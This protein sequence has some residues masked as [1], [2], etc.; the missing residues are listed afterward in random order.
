MG[1]RDLYDSGA[2]EIHDG[3]GEEFQLTVHGR[4]GA[5]WE[6]CASATL[7]IGTGTMFSF[8]T[9]GEEDL[10]RLAGEFAHAANVIRRHEDGVQ[11][12]VTSSVS[13]PG[14]PKLTVVSES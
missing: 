13:V 8:A 14:K 4:D 1:S 5:Q 2:I 7:T 6:R 12:T 3:Q 9:L 11:A 10:R